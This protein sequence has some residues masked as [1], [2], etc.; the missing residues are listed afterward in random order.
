MDCR[1]PGKERQS[2]LQKLHSI[3]QHN[4]VESSRMNNESSRGNED[5]SPLWN[6]QTAAE[7]IPQKQEE[8]GIKA[9]VIVQECGAHY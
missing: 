6:L 8:I 3:S 2:H 1:N 9:N 5:T 4:A 7:C